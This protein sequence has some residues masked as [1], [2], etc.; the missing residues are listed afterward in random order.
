MLDAQT[1]QSTVFI[2]D[3]SQ[4]DFVYYQRIYPTIDLSVLPRSFFHQGIIEHLLTLVDI[5]L[6][7]TDLTTP[8]EKSALLVGDGDNHYN[9][10]TT[11]SDY[12]QAK[13]YLSNLHSNSD[14]N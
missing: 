13:I 3:S 9:S 6:I 8:I 2:A 4:E 1:N 10:I 7:F 11:M 14:V 5:G 12:S